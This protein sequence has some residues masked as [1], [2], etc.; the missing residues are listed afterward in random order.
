M[1]VNFA[2]KFSARNGEI[3]QILNDNAGPAF[4][5]SIVIG[6]LLPLKNY[7]DLRGHPSQSFIFCVNYN[8]SHE[9]KLNEFDHGHFRAIVGPPFYLFSY[10]RVTAFSLFVAG[11]KLIV[12]LVG[13]RF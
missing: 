12:D 8:V 11:R 1:I 4:E 3:F 10:S 2:S 9:L 6:A 7:G 13:R 5:P